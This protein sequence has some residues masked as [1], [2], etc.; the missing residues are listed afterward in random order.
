MSSTQRPPDI[1]DEMKIIDKT[2]KKKISL[3]EMT[4]AKI[5]GFVGSV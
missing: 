5:A 4:D 2:G 3:P 1:D